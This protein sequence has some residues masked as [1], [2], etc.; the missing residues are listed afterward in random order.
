VDDNVDDPDDEAS[1]KADDNV[2]N[3][4]FDACAAISKRHAA[5][6]PRPDPLTP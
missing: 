1:D 2:E 6:D 4:D 5:V 3:T